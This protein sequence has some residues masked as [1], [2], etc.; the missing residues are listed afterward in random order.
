V[1]NRIMN[2]KVQGAFRHLM[3]ALG[4]VLAVH[5]VTDGATWEM[6]IGVGMAGFGFI[7]SWNAAEKQ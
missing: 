3:T 4:P 7:A 5:G 6:Y 1:I 2:P